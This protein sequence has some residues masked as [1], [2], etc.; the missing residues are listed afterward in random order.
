[1]WLGKA[2]AIFTHRTSLLQGIS[3]LGFFNS[4]FFQWFDFYF[5]CACLN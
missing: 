3:V 4:L 2:A 1:M 5:Q